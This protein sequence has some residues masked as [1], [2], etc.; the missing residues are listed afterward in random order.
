MIRLYTGAFFILL[1]VFSAPAWSGQLHL[2]YMHGYKLDGGGGKEGEKAGYRKIISKFKDK[3]YLVVSE[4]RGD[5]GVNDYAEKVSKQVNK[6]IK[7]GVKPSDIIVSG[8]SKGAVISL[9]SAS[10]ISNKDVRYVA[11]AGCTDK[12]DVNYSKIQ[13]KIL[14]IYD[15]GDHKFGSCEDVLSNSDIV[16]FDEI[17]LNTGYG[18]KIFKWKKDKH[19][20]KWMDPM[21]AWIEK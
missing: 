14:S 4:I 10:I 21:V 18:H 9:I 19:I 3:G 1:A 15:I 17:K 13:G 20:K 12:F 2:F 6:L 8:Y 16:S 11:L 7:S 5:E